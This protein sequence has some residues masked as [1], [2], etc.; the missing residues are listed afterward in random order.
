MSPILKH[1]SDILTCRSQ[2]VCVSS[3]LLGVIDG[4][5]EFYTFGLEF[6]QVLEDLSSLRTM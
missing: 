6:H 3:W 1:K 2:V 5:L 4:N